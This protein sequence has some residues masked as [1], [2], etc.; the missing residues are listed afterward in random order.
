MKVATTR[1]I[2]QVVQ[3]VSFLFFL[4]LAVYS[5]ATLGG[6]FSWELPLRFDP[7]AALTTMIAQRRWLV[8]F[9]P[10]AVIL[11]ATLI[12]GRFWCGWLCPLGTLFD[13]FGP[14][15]ATDK[16][17]PSLW[18]G[19]KYG[20]LFVT[21]FAALWGN[22]TLLV[23][24]PL[25]IWMRTLAA[26]ILPGFNWL[27]TQLERV[28]YPLAFLRTP[29]YAIDAALRGSWLGALQAYFGAAALTIGLL[30]AIMV[31][32]LV[33][34][35]A[36]CRYV[37]PLGGILSLVGKASWLK[38]NVSSAC[39][40]CGACAK[41]CRMGTI[42]PKK[43]FASDSGEC[44]LCMDCAAICPTNAITFKLELR[45]DRGWTYDPNRRQVLGALGASLGGLA[46]LKIAPLRQQPDIRRLRPP[47]VDEEQMLSSCIRCG[48]CLR[49]CPTQ[50]LQPS[51]S[52]AGLEGIST[53]ILV[54]RL[55][56]C[57]YT[58]TACGTICPTG[59]IPRVSPAN[60]FAIPIGKAYIDQALCLPWSGR[61]PCIVC[62]EMCPVPQKA[63]TLVERQA[64]DSEGQA[65]TLQAPSVQY[66]RCVGC[67]LCERK[68]PVKGESAIRV[69]I[70]PLS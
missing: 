58:C 14:R 65:I 46:L 17:T 70:D 23:F 59:A 36:W 49:I 64:V 69:R 9:L 6:F 54:P 13:W 31:L 53:P 50:G 35:R 3:V 55:G 37:C 2:R 27:F 67:G 24:D 56:N 40:S 28:L 15:K 32:N 48:A 44:I 25:T 19:L 8:N 38:R 63:I 66:D 62:E 12:L 26:A 21:V 22:L 52:E 47:R 18:R 34:R 51:L 60:K 41:A 42:T 11:I 30:L 68:C 33:R 29:L 1:R 43:A 7:L 45:L 16:G 61:T 10:A 5:T 39:T 4:V 20:I 57:A